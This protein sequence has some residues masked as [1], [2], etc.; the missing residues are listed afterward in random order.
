MFG[1]TVV[2]FLLSTMDTGSQIGVT[3]VL[4]RKAL[5]VD[6]DSPLSEK[7]EL[8]DHES[9]SLPDVIDTWAGSLAVSIILSLPDS[10]TNARCGGEDIDQRFHCHLEGLGPHHKTTVGDPRTVY[11]M[12]RGRG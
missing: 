12:D 4:I 11:S 5:V 6:V 2:N 9:W 1:A 7:S 3:V 8:A 10:T